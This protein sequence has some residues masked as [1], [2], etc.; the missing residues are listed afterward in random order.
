MIG[1]TRTVIYSKESS[2]NQCKHGLWIKVG[3]T[4]AERRDVI[5]GVHKKNFC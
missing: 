2:I 3:C 1:M 4:D 5:L